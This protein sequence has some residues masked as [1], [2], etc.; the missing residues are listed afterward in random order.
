MAVKLPVYYEQSKLLEEINALPENPRVLITVSHC[1]IELYVHILAEGKCKNSKRIV[2]SNRDYPHSTKIVI[3]HEMGVL[4]DRWAEILHWFRKKRNDAAHEVE[5]AITPADLV[6]FEGFQA[7]GLE[8]KEGPVPIDH[9]RK[10]RMLCVEII[11]GFW[12]DH[13]RDL[14]PLMKANY[15]RS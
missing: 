6:L 14:G 8:C 5:F 13:V 4:S 2:S 15:N 3:L 9:P 10:L 7:T 1:Y 11:I 12:N